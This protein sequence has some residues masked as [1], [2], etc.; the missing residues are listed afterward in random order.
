MADEMRQLKAKI[1]DLQV[2]SAQE[3]QQLR[4]GF[5][6]LQANLAQETARRQSL[7]AELA[8]E[9]ARRQRAEREARQWQA[10]LAD[11]RAS[12]QWLTAQAVKPTAV[13]GK[14]LADQEAER[15]CT[16]RLGAQM[17]ERTGRKPQT[18]A[19]MEC[20]LLVFPGGGVRHMVGCPRRP[21]YR[22]LDKVPR[23]P[24]SKVGALRDFWMDPQ[25]FGTSASG[26]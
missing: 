17:G 11:L 22:L 15:V 14:E 16:R 13:Q 20:L 25:E 8:N 3:S 12:C 6:G 9:A 2:S 10:Q 7:E 1:D 24:P 19:C 23:W 18:E 5:A 26:L 4:T 21:L